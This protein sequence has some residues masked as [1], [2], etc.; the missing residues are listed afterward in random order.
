MNAD[1]EIRGPGLYLHVPFCL[2]KCTYCDFYSLP[3]GPDQPRDVARYLSAV[4]SELDLL[5]VPFAPVSVYIGGGTPT[6]L[7][8]SGLGKL[9]AAV[10][11]RIDLSRVS[12]FSCEANP[13]TLQ[14]GVLD[15][16][17]AVGV[18][19]V[20]IGAQSFHPDLLALLGRSHTASDTERAVRE[21]RVAGFS[22]VGLDLMF[23]VPGQSA[24]DWR[25][26]LNR[27][28]TLQPDHLSLYALSLE[29]G[30]RLAR[31][32]ADGRLLAVPDDEAADA[33]ALAR[34]LLPSAG[35]DPYEISNFARPGAACLQNLLYWSGEDYLGV[36][37]AAHSHWKGT[38]WSNP[39]S[40]DTWS[41]ENGGRRFPREDEEHL[42]PADK[43]VE[44]LIF[45]L[46]RIRGVQR[47]EL[48]R[49]TR[50]DLD[51]LR[52]P[53]IRN[54]LDRGLLVPA[55]PDGIRLADSAL[56]I[57]DAVFRDLL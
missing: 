54:L 48:M 38:R 47:A 39:S 40:L 3:D 36:G 6:A 5:P 1:D 55:P 57:S 16:L 23:A 22:Q 42:A 56:F 2:R 44:T 12:E 43:A 10:R 17:R 8:S 52:G 25:A 49:R 26:D 33:Y 46:R 35:F 29:P 37:P 53:E 51:T 20:S 32:V 50:F 34:E 45:G 15:T 14:D 41:G 4:S 30:T 19:R 11:D 7:G 9:G 13:G 21:A 18:T 31:D 28:L 27:A 24:D